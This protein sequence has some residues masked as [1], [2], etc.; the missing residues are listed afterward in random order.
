[1]HS[2]HHRNINTGPWS[3]ISMHPVEHLIYFSSVLI[4]FVLPSHPIHVM[5]HMYLLTL[6]AICGHSGFEGLLVRNKQRLA[7][8]HFHHQLHHRYFEC[9]YGTSE[10]PWDVWF[11][12]FDDGTPAS[13]ARLKQRRKAAKNAGL[14]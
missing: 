11:G 10:M 6:S 14:N 12:S 3:G 7:L 8:G 4:H 5:F 9:N 13:R 2:L 1:M